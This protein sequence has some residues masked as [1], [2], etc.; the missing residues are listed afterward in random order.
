M[1]NIAFRDVLDEITHIQFGTG[2]RTDLDNITQD[3]MDSL[4]NDNLNNRAVNQIFQNEDLNLNSIAYDSNNS[5]R[6]LNP[7]NFI[8]YR[9]LFTQTTLYQLTSGQL[10]EN[11]KGILAPEVPYYQLTVQNRWAFPIE[12]FKIERKTDKQLVLRNYLFPYFKWSKFSEIAFLR[13]NSETSYTTLIYCSFPTINYAP[14]MLSSIYLNLFLEYNFEEVSKKLSFTF[15]TSD[16]QLENNT[17]FYY[18]EIPYLDKPYLDY[19]NYTFQY[20]KPSQNSITNQYYFYQN[21]GYNP[22]IYVY[23]KI[24]TDV[25]GNIYEKIETDSI[26]IN[27]N[28]V[29]KIRINNTNISPFTGK[30]ILT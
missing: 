23:K 26:F 27:K 1:K 11:N 13:K 21:L 22:Y 19:L 30:L 4:L 9:N 10:I 2:K 24:G 28:G 16:W 15:N 3:T 14:E 12:Y 18:L 7:L 25:D 5:Y 20:V 29:I 17:N 8:A 6:F